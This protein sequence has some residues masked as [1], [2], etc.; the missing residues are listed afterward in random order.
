MPG[1]GWEDIFFRK[2]LG[3]PF[4]S[5]PKR[6]G[7]PALIITSALFTLFWGYLVYTGSITMLWPLLGM[8][9]QLLAACALIIGTTMIIGMGKSKYSWITAVPGIFMVPVTMTAGYYLVKV[10]YALGNYLLVVI[11]RYS[12]DSSG[13]HF[14]FGL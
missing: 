13:R 2:L 6:G 5:S 10:N 8:S 4:R 3:R 9:N 1:H 7:Y 12:H 11:Y 14:Y